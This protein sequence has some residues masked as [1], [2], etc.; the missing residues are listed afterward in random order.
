MRIISLLGLGIP[1]LA[2]SGA[3]AYGSIR[4]ISRSLAPPPID[5]SKA[6]AVPQPKAT[7]AALDFIAAGQ[8]E[9]DVPQQAA[10]V[11]PLFQDQSIEAAAPIGL[12][13]TGLDGARP[14]AVDHDDGMVVIAKPEGIGALRQ[15]RVIVT[16]K[17]R[18]ERPR[19]TQQKAAKH[20]FK[21]PWQTGI[22][23]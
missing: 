15:P 5:Q 10:F 13:N 9:W 2:V 19:L 1:V 8:T 6:T 18:V 22:F 12:V 17:Q 4:E 3:V 20:N 11:T 21:M 7:A 16:A 14:S 23:Q